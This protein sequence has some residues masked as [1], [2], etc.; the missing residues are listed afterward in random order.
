M[1]FPLLTTMNE[2]LL[3]DVPCSHTIDSNRDFAVGD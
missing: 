1:V 3:N 2:L